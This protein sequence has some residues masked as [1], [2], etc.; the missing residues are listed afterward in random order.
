M[1]LLLIISVDMYKDSTIKYG[2]MELEEVYIFLFRSSLVCTED[3]DKINM[4]YNHIIQVIMHCSFFNDRK[5]SFPSFLSFW[6]LEYIICFI[7]TCMTLILN[8]ASSK[9]MEIFWDAMPKHKI[10]TKF[11]YPISLIHDNLV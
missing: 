10:Y 11:Q 3:L 7:F 9:T 2:K 5:L 4:Q 1:D 6:M 8:I